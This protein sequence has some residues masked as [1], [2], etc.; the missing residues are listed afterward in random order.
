LLAFFFARTFRGFIAFIAFITF[1]LIVFT[2]VP[3]P[4]SMVFSIASS[5]LVFFTA[6]VVFLLAF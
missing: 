3:F 4:V 6:I 2:A 1:I 5:A